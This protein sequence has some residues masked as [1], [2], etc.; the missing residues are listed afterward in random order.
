M[1][2]LPIMQRSDPNS[3]LAD[4]Y[5]PALTMSFDIGGEPSGE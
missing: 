2:R 4:I 5:S 3:F 1:S